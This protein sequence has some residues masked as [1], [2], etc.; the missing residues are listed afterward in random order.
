MSGNFGVFQQNGDRYE[1]HSNDD[2]YVFEY[3]SNNNKM[4]PS[5]KAIVYVGE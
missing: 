4:F 5:W 3:W 2:L 1:F